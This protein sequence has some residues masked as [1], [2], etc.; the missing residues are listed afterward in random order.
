MKVVTF[1]LCRRPFYSSKVL[2]SWAKVRG[3]EE[4]A[5]QFH[6]EPVM[7]Q[8][9]Q[10]LLAE[11]FG[12]DVGREVE[13]I[14][15]EVREGV[16]KNPLKALRHGFA[17]PEVEQVVL[18]EEDVEVAPDVVEY[19]DFALG[20]ADIAC[21]WSREDG[22]ADEV[23][24]RESFNPWAWGVNRDTF[25]KVLDP[26]WDVDYGSA[27]DRGPGGWDCNIGLRVVPDHGLRV[28]F[29]RA[30]RSRHIGRWVGVHQGSSEYDVQ[31]NMPAGFRTDRGPSDYRMV[32]DVR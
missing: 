16:L 21:A 25:T 27:D 7:E 24:I 13:V 5:V 26:S 30:A 4:W 9:A 1:T 29:P 32:S 22:P 31:T 28:A 11:K 6:I 23:V 10:V 2:N 15:N 18:A 20:H 3:I 19:L 12:R 8:E 14:R 17:N